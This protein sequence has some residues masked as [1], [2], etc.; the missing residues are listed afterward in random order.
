[1]LIK[2]QDN[3]AISQIILSCCT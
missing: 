1:V 2:C 3:I